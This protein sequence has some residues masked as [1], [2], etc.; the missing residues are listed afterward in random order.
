MIVQPTSSPLS[1]AEHLL[2]PFVPRR[3]LVLR[4]W[5]G[6]ICGYFHSSP[7]SINLA[8]QDFEL[9]E[10]TSFIV[11]IGHGRRLA[12]ASKKLC[13]LATKTSNHL[14]SSKV[15]E[16]PWKKK[17]AIPRRFW[18][19]DNSTWQSILPQK[20]SSSLPPFS[21]KLLEKNPCF[22]AQRGAFHNPFQTNGNTTLAPS[23]F[24]CIMKILFLYPLS[25]LFHH[26][27][28]KKGGSVLKIMQ[29]LLIRLLMYSQDLSRTV[30][31]PFLAAFQAS[32]CFIFVFSAYSFL[33]PNMD[34]KVYVVAIYLP[35]RDRVS[36]LGRAEIGSC[37]SPKMKDQG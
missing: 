29:E 23:H 12:N 6:K 32:F 18:L 11:G 33:M 16:N 3:F 17:K 1:Y 36:K 14:Y 35:S 8:A 25:Y 5:R 26:I 2:L 22:S 13:K 31:A 27:H 10:T 24:P 19:T 15:N 4:M 9:K 20:V 30:H 21:Q 7:L 28:R 37:Q 34:G